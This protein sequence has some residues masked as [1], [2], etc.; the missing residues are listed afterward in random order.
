MGLILQLSILTVIFSNISYTFQPTNLGVAL[1]GENSK[2][3]AT[4]SIIK[5][6][7][8]STSRHVFNPGI[9]KKDSIAWTDTLT[10]DPLKKYVVR[11]VKF[12]ESSLRVD[13]LEI[14]DLTSDI[15][16]A[17][18]KEQTRIVRTKGSYN[19][20]I[21]L[22]FMSN[23]MGERSELPIQSERAISFY[24]GIEIAIDSLKREGIKL[25]VQVFDSKKDVEDMD[26]IIERLGDMEWDLIIGPTSTDALKKLAVYA[27]E[28]QVPLISPF[29]TNPNIAQENHFFIQVAPSFDVTSMHL[30]SFIKQIKLASSSHVR[31]LKYVLVGTK[32][33]SLKMNQIQKTYKLV[34]NNEN[35]E[36][37]QV[38]T[39][40]GIN[41]SVLMKYFDRSALNVVIIPSDKSEQF[42]YSTLR[43]ISSLYNKLE[44]HGGFQF[45]VIGTPMWKYF[46]RVNFEYY[47]NLNL[48]I[49]DN[50][51]VDKE[52]KKNIQFEEGYRDRYGIAPREF[53]YIGFDVMTYFGRLLKKYGTGF[54]DH[55]DTEATKG[56]H[57][58]FA[59]DPVYKEVKLLDGEELK[60]KKVIERFENKS[61]NIVK[62]EAFEFKEVKMKLD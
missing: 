13:T 24:E 62:F 35:A 34:E 49:V 6:K 2:E 14:I 23:L 20:A 8:D 47:D 54:P 7:S 10:E 29:N 61:T 21:I 41:V 39:N 15:V 27:K 60:E 45:A 28:K 12:P 19:V 16:S 59:F 1:Y 55:F 25:Q 17:A 22:P 57:T 26:A 5:P 46:E 3:L 4:D 56:R 36:I 44:K 11:Y 52:D 42:V 40:E 58:F 32:E 48:H 53:A 30:V 31:K 18:F 33:D 37:S 43:E 51:F 50:F 9:T 38:F